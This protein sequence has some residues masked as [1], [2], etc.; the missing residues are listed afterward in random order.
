MA[1]DTHPKYTLSIKVKKLIFI[2]TIA[3][4]KMN[5]FDFSSVCEPELTADNGKKRD[6]KYEF[7]EKTNWYVPRISPEQQA[8][9]DEITAKEKTRSQAYEKKYSDK[10]DDARKARIEK[11]VRAAQKVLNRAPWKMSFMTKMCCIVCDGRSQHGTTYSWKKYSWT[12]G[13]I[14]SVIK[15]G[16]EVD[17]DF[18]LCLEKDFTNK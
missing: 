6:V 10:I 7:D 3:A 18:I 4:H 15:H 5:I 2:K 13:L 8:V 1:L 12:E 16:I 11:A 9:N 14:H 17:E